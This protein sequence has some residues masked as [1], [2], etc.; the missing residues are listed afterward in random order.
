MTEYR[1]AISNLA[2]TDWVPV[3]MVYTQVMFIAVRCYFIIAIV[4]KQYVSDSQ[5]IAINSTVGVN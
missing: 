3:P 4:G 2:R 5:H 1:L